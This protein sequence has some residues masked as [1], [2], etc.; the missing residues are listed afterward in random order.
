MIERSQSGHLIVAH[1]KYPIAVL[2]R[3]VLL[4]IEHNAAGAVALQTNRIYQNG[5]NLSTVMY[6][7]GLS[8]PFDEPLYIGGPHNQNRVYVIHSLDWSS[9]TTNKLNDQVGIST[10]LSVLIALSQ[11]QGPEYFRAVAGFTS[12]DAG[13][14]DG[15]ISGVKPWSP[16]HSWNWVTAG[17]SNLF[18]VEA[19]QQWE[20]VIDQT[21]KQ[22]IAAWF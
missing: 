22:Q 16:V 2:R 4:V 9:P 12:W 13:E 18:E 17:I 20:A 10:D 7:A 19:E 6:S 14:L 5:I 1:P 21:S 3:S 11:N 8:C 15:E